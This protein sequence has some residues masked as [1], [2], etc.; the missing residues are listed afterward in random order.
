MTVLATSI[1]ILAI[2]FCY[3]NC[4]LKNAKDEKENI[5]NFICL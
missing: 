5:Y 2:I 3:Y 4:R 1:I